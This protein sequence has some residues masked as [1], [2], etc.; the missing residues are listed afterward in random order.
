MRILA[1][2]AALSVSVLAQR[3][4]VVFLD[5][6]TPCSDFDE[7]FGSFE[8]MKTK[9]KGKSNKKKTK[10]F[11]NLICENGHANVWSTKPIKC[12]AKRSGQNAGTY[13]WKPS[14]IKDAA[15]LCTAKEKCP[16][17]KTVYNVTNKLLS[18]EK[19]IEG[20]RTFYNFS[21]A[22]MEKDGR[23]FAMIPFPTDYVT[24]T[25][26]FNKPSNVR[27]KWMKVKN[28]IVRCVRADKEKFQ[29]D[30]AFY[31]DMYDESF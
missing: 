25:C 27:C 1:S 7:K 22:D 5:E 21:C 8:G 14:K 29:N 2:I 13:Q 28:S 4:N 11:C 26:N 20:R 30:P 17:L 16:Q 18:W 24:C 23:T 31:D 6:S 19:S 15:D 3:Q 10:Q 12:K 9:C